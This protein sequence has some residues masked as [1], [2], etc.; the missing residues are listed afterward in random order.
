MSE[1]DELLI[2]LDQWAN[3]QPD[4]AKAI[5]KLLAEVFELRKKNAR[6]RNALFS[7]GTD[8]DMLAMHRDRVA[9]N[10]KSALV[11]DSDAD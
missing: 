2:G 5:R 3:V 9:N 11:L 10:V 6:L 8:L 7:V 1:Y 4:A